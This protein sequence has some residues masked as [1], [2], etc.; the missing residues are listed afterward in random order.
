VAPTFFT[1]AFGFGAYEVLH[2]R[3]YRELHHGS[4]DPILFS[5]CVLVV[6]TMWWMKLLCIR[7][8]IQRDRR[9][10]HPEMPLR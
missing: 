4:F 3:A 5:V 9:M 10:K 2:D 1:W 8:S 7:Q 6:G